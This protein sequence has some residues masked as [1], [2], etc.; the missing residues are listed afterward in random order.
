MTKNRLKCLGRRIELESK[1][2]PEIRSINHTNRK[3]EQNTQTKNL[4]LSNPNLAITNLRT[5]E[6]KIDIE[7][8]RD[9]WTEKSLKIWTHS[10]KEISRKSFQNLSSFLNLQKTQKKTSS[11][12]HKMTKKLSHRPMIRANQ[13]T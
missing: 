11:E 8:W 7:T 5:L 12:N 13:K 3:I 9:L 6:I 4:T 2:S 10:L 1:R